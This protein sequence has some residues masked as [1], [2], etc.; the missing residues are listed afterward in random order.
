[1][2]A[3]ENHMSLFACMTTF[4]IMNS[5]PKPR[6]SIFFSNFEGIQD[7]CLYVCVCDILS[8]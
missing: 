5:L 1:M 7:V 3:G 2:G 4:Y 8:I 6:N